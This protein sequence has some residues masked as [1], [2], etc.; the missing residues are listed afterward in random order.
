[1]NKT[2]YLKKCI[3]KIDEALV[4]FNHWLLINDDIK[5]TPDDII[6]WTELL[7]FDCLFNASLY[8]P[9]DINFLLFSKIP[10]HM[11]LVINML[12]VERYIEYMSHLMFLIIDSIFSN[13]ILPSKV[14]FSDLKENK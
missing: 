6:C 5:P 14:S 1:M 13:E 8:K 7:A 11:E 4:Y 9:D 3:K 2:N 12:G 10:K